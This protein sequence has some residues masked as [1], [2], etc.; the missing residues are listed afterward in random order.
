MLWQALI[1]VLGGPWGIFLES[2]HGP[3]EKLPPGMLIHEPANVENDWKI[4]N[5]GLQRTSQQ[6][7]NL[8][9]MD[10]PADHGPA[11]RGLQTLG[12]HTLGW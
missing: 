9:T 3:A 2:Q 7:M 1:Q 10:G 12:L 11:N 5:M 4:R 6:T 8:H